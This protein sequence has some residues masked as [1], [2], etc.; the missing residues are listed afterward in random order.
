[1]DGVEGRGGARHVDEIGAALELA[2]I[3]LAMDLAF[4]GEVTQEHEVVRRFAGDGASFG[5]AEGSAA[6]LS[7]TFCRLV[8]DGRL[9]N[10][11]PDTSAEPAV[12]NLPMTEQARIGAYLGVPL[13][14]DLRQYM[15]CCLAHEP[16]PLD[17]ADVRFMHGVGA[18]V[19][20]ALEASR[21]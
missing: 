15:L 3:E 16:R 5:V 10:A 1:M 4:L 11:V 8:L 6:E 21:N 7:H 2:R 18:T 14:H 17:D 12:R 13:D 9:A 20:A 19:L